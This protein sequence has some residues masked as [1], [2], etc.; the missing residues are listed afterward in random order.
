[1]GPVLY[2]ILKACKQREKIWIAVPVVSV[3]FTGIIYLTSLMYRVNVP[4]VDTVSLIS[5]DPDWQAERIYTNVTCPKV[6]DYTL[7]LNQKYQNISY[8]T[9]SY[10][11]DSAMSV[12]S[13]GA[14]DGTYSYMIKDTAK[15]K[16]FTFHNQETFHDN[17]FVAISSE[18]NKMGT[19][20]YDLNCT[21]SGFSGSVTNQTDYDLEGVVVTFENHIY[22]AGDLKAGQTVE[23][24]PTNLKTTTGYGTFNQLYTGGT[25]DRKAYRYNQ[26]DSMMETYYMHVSEYG[27]GIIWAKIDGYQPDYVEEGKV[28]SAG[29]G[30]VYTAYEAEYT[31]VKGAYY[32]SLDPMITQ[33]DG[34]YDTGDRTMYNNSI[35]ITYSFTGYPGI[36]RLELL[37]KNSDITYGTYADVYAYN[38]DTD[39]YEQIFKDSDVIAGDE[40]SKYVVNNTIRLRYERDDSRGEQGYLP[41]I[42]ARGDE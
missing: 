24:D 19:I 15:G 6:R 10:S 25:G 11:Y 28:K 20:A 37:S 21:T 40:L 38:P 18:Q 4:L 17:S 14:E 5:L 34:D 29:V 22:L 33:V 16:Q 26:I 41:R 36:T 42:C 31:D 1:M 8:D 30:I 27:K 7:V 35:Q 39:D 2:L 9:D 12:V 23:I 32:Q 3:L 13:S